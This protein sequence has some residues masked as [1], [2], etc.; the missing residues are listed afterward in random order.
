MASAWTGLGK[1]VRDALV[2]DTG[3]GGLWETSGAAKVG[4]VYVDRAPEQAAL[5]YLLVTPTGNTREHVFAASD[6]TW[7]V[8]F[9]VD[10]YTPAVNGLEKHELIGER[11]RTL[12]DRVALTVS[13]WT[14][15]QAF[16]DSEQPSQ[17]ESESFRT[18]FDFRVVMGR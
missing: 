15:S 9:Q 2:A 1:A 8:G 4:A 17:V 18:A 11:V 10:L 6:E 14:V 3:S 5:D 16:L 13:G 12:L 7:E